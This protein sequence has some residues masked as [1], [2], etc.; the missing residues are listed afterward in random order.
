MTRLTP[1]R[2]LWAAAL[3]VGIVLGTTGCAGGGGARG[4]ADQIS[5][6][7]VERARAH[8]RLAALDR[9]VAE[10]NWSIG[11][12]EWSVRANVYTLMVADGVSE[13]GVMADLASMGNPAAVSVSATGTLEGTSINTYHPAG[14]EYDYALLGE[15]LTDLN[16][17]PW[18]A[19]PTVYPDQAEGFN[20]EISPYGLS[21]CAA[22]FYLLLCGVRASIY[23]A[24]SGA[25]QPAAGEAAA[26]PHVETQSDGTTE[27][28][29][30]VPFAALGT[31]EEFPYYPSVFP[32]S[33]AFAALLEGEAG[34]QPVLIRLWQTAAGEPI[35]AEVNGTLTDEEHTIEIQA[36]WEKTGE[37]AAED[38]AEPPSALDVTHMT[39]EQYQAFLDLVD[40]RRAELRE[41]ADD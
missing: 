5:L 31:I 21:F 25:H 9:F 8:E 28:S 39:T 20:V 26:V 35:K 24:L 30:T 4:H 3:A 2:R 1:N 10:H 12:G 23:H 27:L 6:A 40:Q 38:F 32:P 29:L 13:S 19:V 22:T 16:P 18:I 33:E 7:R 15:K 17:T 36:G 41:E 11:E 34:R 14:S 37:A